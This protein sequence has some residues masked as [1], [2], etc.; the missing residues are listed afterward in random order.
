MK[1][2]QAIPRS[3][4]VVWMVLSELNSRYLS[5]QNRVMKNEML[6]KY[7]EAVADAIRGS[8]RPI[9]SW[10]AFAEKAHATTDGIHFDLKSLD[11]S[12]EV[13]HISRY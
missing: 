4:E 8:S 11:I 7:N 6:A 1:L 3:T 9:I 10:S 13:N 2:L 12:N 5:G